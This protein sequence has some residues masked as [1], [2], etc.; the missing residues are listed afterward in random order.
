MSSG[1]T[2]RSVRA[3]SFPPP[4]PRLLIDAPSPALNYPPTH[5]STLLPALEPAAADILL[6]LLALLARLTAH[7]HTSGHTP[8]TLSP[9]FGPLLFGL[10]APALPFAHAYAAYLR[11]AHAAEHVLL[12]FARWED[13]GA[14][15]PGP[16][17]ARLK[18]WIRNY[19]AT[20]PSHAP[21]AATRRGGQ[22]LEAGAPQA[23]RGARTTRVLS[24]RRNVRA[25]APDLVRSGAGWAARGRG[26]PANALG[27][28]K[29]WA[30]VTPDGRAP[31]YS[32]AF[33]KRLELPAAVQPE[34]MPT[35]SSAPSASSSISSGTASTLV[36]SDAFS[37]FKSLTDAK[38]GEFEN[39]GFGSFEAGDR[40]LQFD[41]TEGARAVRPPLPS[42]SA[43][44]LTSPQARHAKRQTLSWDDFSNAGFSRMDA[45][46][47]GVLQF[48]AP[49]SPAAGAPAQSEE[50][51]RRL[52][53]A[54]RA[55]P[56]FGWD[57]APVLGAEEFVEEAFVDVFCDL[58]YGAGW[59]DTD[60]VD[61]V[62]REC[63]WALVGLYSVLS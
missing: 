35:L 27:A 54:Q 33:R 9:L 22:K 48:T 8:P 45:P 12:A 62:E 46:L 3:R 41:L 20:L 13:S 61:E 51:R 11:A 40:K 17:A 37:D 25:Y 34:A 32:D 52:K 5:F 21:A 6:T 63:N 47:D 18:D 59:M 56:A 60:R 58:V 38:W 42:S 7:S 19:P 2:P 14:G 49:P 30:R 28:S 23:R 16:V 55:L 31:R 10:G 1:E 24:V 44:P 4:L 36:D 15:G 43:S 53:K 29:D 39:L 57:T 26:E 50:M